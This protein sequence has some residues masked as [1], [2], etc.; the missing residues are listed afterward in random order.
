MKNRLELIISFY[1]GRKLIAVLVS[2]VLVLIALN[3]DGA[4]SDIAVVLAIAIWMALFALTA[5]RVGEL[6]RREAT[7]L[8]RIAAAETRLQ[9]GD[10][11]A[12]VV[13]NEIE[14]T[15]KLLRTTVANVARLSA[16]QPARGTKASTNKP[17]QSVAPES[18]EVTTGQVMSLFQ[19]VTG[20]PEQDVVSIV[21][22]CW[23][24]ATFVTDTISSLQ[25]Q[26]FTR[27]RAIIV[28]DGSTD[29]SVAVIRSACADDE[30]FSVIE[31]GDNRGL[32]AARNTGLGAVDT[33]FV[34]FLDSDDFFF[35]E[36]LAERTRHLLGWCDR[37]EVVGVFSAIDQVEEHV[38][39]DDATPSDRRNRTRFHDHLTAAGRCPFNCHAPLMRTDVLQRFGGFDESM[40]QGAEDWDLWQ[41]IM[42]HGYVFEATPSV[43]AV[44]RQKKASMVRTMPSSHLAEADRLSERVHAPLAAADIVPGTPYVFS[45]AIG[46]YQHRL[47]T[48]E[49]IL[50]FLGLSYMT[51]GDE[52]VQESIQLL[53]P[54]FWSVVDR[55]LSV[56]GLLDAG[57]RRGFALDL[58][59]FR[60]LEGKIAPIRKE[61]LERLAAHAASAG[62]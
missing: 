34:G 48:A 45:E 18:P 24:D 6:E 38:R 33:P 12:V 37:T 29:D 5:N 31:H 43:L 1:S 56:S 27:F 44:Y 59:S 22:P 49:R 8:E 25:S 36:N 39:F 58:E 40:R 42:R 11:R 61:L 30:R 21:V 7:I 35:R 52:Q 51:D 28:D 9:H 10:D 50:Q 20:L 3:I 54:T 15:K 17:Q 26:S 16:P 41:R 60:H 4:L 62:A 14:E 47:A 19:L 46:T 2:I 13:T 57:I 23:N 55:H 32:S 53:D